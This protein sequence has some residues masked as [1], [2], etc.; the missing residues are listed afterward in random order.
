MKRIKRMTM[1]DKYKYPEFNNNYMQGK[2]SDR[3]LG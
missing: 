3:F 1:T 2:D